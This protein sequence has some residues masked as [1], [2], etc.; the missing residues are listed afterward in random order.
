VYEE[1][2]PYWKDLCRR[3]Q[4]GEVTGAAGL[5]GAD[6]WVQKTYKELGL[7]WQWTGDD[8]RDMLVGRIMLF[9]WEQGIAE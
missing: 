8:Y 9:T 1:L 2:I 4:T 7:N 6:P 5:S 3:V